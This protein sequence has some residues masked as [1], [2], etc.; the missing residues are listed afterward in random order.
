MTFFTWKLPLST[1]LFWLSLS[2]YAILP[3][4]LTLSLIP[5]SLPSSLLLLS[6]DDGVYVSTYVC[7]DGI[8]QQQQT[9]LQLI[10]V[11]DGQAVNHALSS[12]R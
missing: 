3:P 11:K 5:P 12:G 8:Q 9:M 7:I 4:F 2:I 10:E 1:L 6:Y